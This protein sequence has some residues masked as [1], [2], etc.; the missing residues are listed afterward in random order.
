MTY[1]FERKRH[2]GDRTF[3]C[4]TITRFNNAVSI[5]GNDKLPIRFKITQSF[6]MIIGNSFFPPSSGDYNECLA[7]P[8]TEKISCFFQSVGVGGWNP[9][10]DSVSC[11]KICICSKKIFHKTQ[12]ELQPLS[13]ERSFFVDAC[14]STIII[15]VVLVGTEG[16]RVDF[17]VLLLLLLCANNDYHCNNLRVNVIVAW[18]SIVSGKWK[19]I[20][21]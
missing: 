13:H 4:S 14:L 15:I 1:G 2:E 7:P 18:L 21:K 10:N 5:K 3:C 16:K 8:P 19:K 20:W 9:G 11:E 17:F 6:C 12:T